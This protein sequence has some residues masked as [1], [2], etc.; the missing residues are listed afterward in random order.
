MDDYLSPFRS[1]PL[2]ATTGPSEWPRGKIRGGEAFSQLG[3]V[4]VP[5]A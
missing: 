4:P 2:A 5:Q 1:G 3:R